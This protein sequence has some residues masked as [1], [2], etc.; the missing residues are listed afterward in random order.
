M[1]ADQWRIERTNLLGQRSTGQIRDSDAAL[2]RA[3]TRAQLAAGRTIAQIDLGSGTSNYKGDPDVVRYAVT[4]EDI[5]AFAPYNT[6]N[7]NNQ[8]GIVGKVFSVNQPFINVA[9]SEHEG[10][11]FGLRYVVPRF[12]WGNVVLNSEWSYFVRSRSVTRPAN[13][14]AIE[15]DDMNASGVARWRGTSNVSWRRGPWSGNLG[16]YYVGP[17]QGGASTTLAV[18]DSLGRP[19]YIARQFT[20]GQFV[21]R[22]VVDSTITYN[23]SLGYRFGPDAAKWLRGTRVRVGVVNLFDK[24][25]PLTTGAFG[26]DPG[27]SQN[28][29]P[30]RTWSLEIAKPF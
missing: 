24:E 5:A 21:H 11:D 19:N 29:L 27:V 14:P 17:T 2:I 7:P 26:Y 8:Q 16:A 1:T 30:G 4:P 6:A 3:Y 18:W 28:L 15:T 23:A 20:G 13:L 10:V 9:T 12:P 25:P 22:Y